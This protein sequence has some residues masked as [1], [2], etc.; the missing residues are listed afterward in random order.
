MNGKNE[1]FHFIRIFIKIHMDGRGTHGKYDIMNDFNAVASSSGD[2]F[3]VQY[4]Q[5]AS[6]PHL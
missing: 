6:I 3:L 5:C 1:L 4:V 2:S